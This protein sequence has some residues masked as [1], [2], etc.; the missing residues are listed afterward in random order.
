M[1]EPD[2]IAISTANNH[3]STP[4]VAASAA[5]YL[6]V[7]A[8]IRNSLTT[9]SDIFGARVSG[10]G[11]VLEPD[12]ISI[13]VAPNQQLL[14]IVTPTSAGY[15]VAWQEASVGVS[16]S[17]DIASIAVNRDGTLTDTSPT[18]VSQAFDNQTNLALA[19]G[20]DNQVA[21]IFQTP[22]GSDARI[23][24]SGISFPQVEALPRLTVGPLA[25][26]AAFAFQLTDAPTNFIVEA[27]TDLARWT[28]VDLEFGVTFDP[29]TKTSALF[30]LDHAAT[31]FNQRFYRVKSSP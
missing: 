1:L 16:N 13:R 30:F 15:F 29:A 12:G 18:F 22:R 8:D 14:P 21:A 20:S 25:T 6:V 7:W 28:R 4:A 11:A 27:S 3:Q 10:A 17:F 24:G 9:G 19:T 31:N 5:D 26:T 23:V 2:G